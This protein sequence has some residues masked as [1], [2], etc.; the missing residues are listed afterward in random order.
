MP[1][2]TKFDVAANFLT[3]AP[4]IL[5]NYLLYYGIILP[6]SYMPMFVLHGV[7]DVLFVLIYYVF[8][9]RKKVVLTNLRNAFPE[10]SEKE[11]YQIAR[12][13]YRHFCS[14]MVESIKAFSISNKTLLKYFKITN[15]ELLDK[16]YAQNKS[17]ILVT[18]HY[19]NWEWAALSLALQSKY[20]AS[21]IYQPIRNKFFDRVMQQTRSKNGLILIPPKETADYFIKLK[22]RL[23][24]YGFIADQSPSNPDKGQWLTFLN[25][26]TSVLTGTERY[27]KMHDCV[28]L[29]GKIDMPKRGHYTLT[30][31]PVSDK[32]HAT[33]DGEITIAHTQILESIIKKRPELWLWTHRRWKH[34]PKHNV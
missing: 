7:A 20:Q 9:Y 29:F 18:G 3:F 2:H 15:T 8:P 34:K 24:A 28:V 33:Q 16:Y 21:G 30:Y 14:I 12:K 22:D 13:F 32:P 25:Q 27:A 19:G 10:K 1:L 4:M 17:V 6:L 26:P 23:V 31:I 11:I 5:L